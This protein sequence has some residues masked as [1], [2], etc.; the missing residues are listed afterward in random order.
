MGQ[1][2]K[3]KKKG[4]RKEEKQK[5]KK[6]KKPPPPPSQTSL[7]QTPAYN[8]PEQKKQ[9]GTGIVKSQV[10]TTDS[11]TFNK[12]PPVK[13]SVMKYLFWLNLK[14]NGPAYHILKALLVQHC[15]WRYFEAYIKGFLTKVWKLL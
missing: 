8:V 3:K 15:H 7:R 5:E 10:Y 14:N 9:N 4:Q 11:T 12:V 1:H 13:V 2:K 6:K